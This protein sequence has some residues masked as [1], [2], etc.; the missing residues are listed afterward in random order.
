MLRREGFSIG[1]NRINCIY[2]ELGLQLRNK[3]RKQ[4]VKDKLRNDRKAATML[5]E[6]WAM[7]FVHDRRA[8][9]RK[10]RDFTVGKIEARSL[11]PNSSS[12]LS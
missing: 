11:L 4:E 9:G 12:L 5:N 6:T 2:R 10:L 1:M 7:D 8:T 3:T